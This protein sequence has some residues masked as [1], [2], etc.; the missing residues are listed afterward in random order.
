MAG[1]PRDDDGIRLVDRVVLLYRWC[2]SEGILNVMPPFE[3]R[4]LVEKSIDDTSRADG[5]RWCVVHGEGTR[6]ALV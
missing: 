1:V 5:V 2:W 6:M 4:V 3:K